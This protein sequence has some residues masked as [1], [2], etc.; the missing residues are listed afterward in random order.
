MIIVLALQGALLLGGADQ[1]DWFWA[2]NYFGISLVIP[3]VAERISC[4]PVDISHLY[5]SEI[6]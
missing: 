6:K 5:W 3:A 1:T 2:R 4:Y